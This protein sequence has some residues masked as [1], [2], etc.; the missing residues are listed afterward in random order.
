MDLILQHFTSDL[1][2]LILLVDERVKKEYM[3]LEHISNQTLP[4]YINN[5]KIP[6]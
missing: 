3:R 6:V 2:L 4:I 1:F 5:K